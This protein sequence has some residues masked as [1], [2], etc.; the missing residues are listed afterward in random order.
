[1]V[2]CANQDTLRAVLDDET[3]IISLHRAT[4]PR[5]EILA[6]RYLRSPGGLT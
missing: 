5:V 3:A 1:M 2:H 4:F 6:S